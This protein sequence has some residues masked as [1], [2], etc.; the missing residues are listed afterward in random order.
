[1]LRIL[2][3]SVLFLAVLLTACAMT[4]PLV[5][6]ERQEFGMELTKPARGIAALAVSR[7]GNY[8]ITGDA[9]IEN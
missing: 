2:K 3:I 6:L 1:M 4:R 7:D 5:R 9:E 8:A